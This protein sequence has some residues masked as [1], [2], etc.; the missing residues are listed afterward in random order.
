[1]L[2]ILGM[3]IFYSFYD[4]NVK[5]NNINVKFFFIFCLIFELKTLTKY[6]KHDF[7]IQKI[8]LNTFIIIND[9]KTDIIKL[10]IVC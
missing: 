5:G 9:K 6:K 3:L 7:F 1:M 10:K 8:D 2:Y 4:T